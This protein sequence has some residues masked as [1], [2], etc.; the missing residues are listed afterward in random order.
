MRWRTSETRAALHLPTAL[1]GVLSLALL[2][3]VVS[4]QTAEL[5]LMSLSLDIFS[6]KFAQDSPTGLRSP[7]E[8]GVTRVWS[9]VGMF[10]TARPQVCFAMPISP[11]PPSTG[12]CGM[13]AEELLVPS[14]T[15]PKPAKPEPNR[16]I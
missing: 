8:H 4:A 3:H 6:P 11:P 2:P 16:I 10:P 12:P 13:S 5:A 9:A 15:A 14:S 7:G 1:V